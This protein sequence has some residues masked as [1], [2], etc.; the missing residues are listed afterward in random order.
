[1]LLMRL[2]VFVIFSTIHRFRIW[3]MD[4]G[5]LGRYNQNEASQS[6]ILYIAAFPLCCFEVFAFDLRSNMSLTEVLWPLITKRRPRRNL[7]LSISM[8][9][10]WFCLN[11]ND[12]Q[13]LFSMNDNWLFSRSH[14]AI[15]FG[16]SLHKN[17]TIYLPLGLYHTSVNWLSIVLM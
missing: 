10:D 12:Q 8:Q 15:R 5:G 14:N 16:G 11:V 6:S 17:N 4:A 1:M 3:R 9:T 2:A 13:W 7:M